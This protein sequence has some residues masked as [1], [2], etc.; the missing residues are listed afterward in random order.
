MAQ[1]GTVVVLRVSYVRVTRDVEAKREFG[2]GAAWKAMSN[3]EAAPATVSGERL[4]NVSLMPNGIGKA[5]QP[6]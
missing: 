3:T 4:S 1:F 5:R 6:Q 2:E